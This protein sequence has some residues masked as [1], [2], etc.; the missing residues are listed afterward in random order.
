MGA[1]VLIFRSPP[2]SP[3]PVRGWLAK[4]EAAAATQLSAALWRLPLSIC[5]V[6]MMGG[7]FSL[8]SEVS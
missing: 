7:A 6:S 3:T 4:S 5:G 8:A 2:L 1:F